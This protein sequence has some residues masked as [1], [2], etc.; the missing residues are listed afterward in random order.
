MFRRSFVPVV[1]SFAAFT[2]RSMT[3]EA[4]RSSGKVKWFDRKKGFGFITPDAAGDDI[5]VHFSSI[6]VKGFRALNGALDRSQ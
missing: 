3:S 1:N 2:R 6:N 5:F 4:T